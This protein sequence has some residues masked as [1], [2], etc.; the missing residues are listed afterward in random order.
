MALPYTHACSPTHA[1]T[2]VII[3]QAVLCVD[4]KC[5]CVLLPDGS[6]CS[7]LTSNTSSGLQFRGSVYDDE[8]TI[9]SINRSEFIQNLML[10]LTIFPCGVTVSESLLEL[11]R[12]K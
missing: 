1:F 6:P 12:N 9:I 5:V 3:I 2:I 4:H 11:C 10:V 7:N 8:S